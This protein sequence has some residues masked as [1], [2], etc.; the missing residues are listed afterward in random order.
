M[1][2]SNLLRGLF[3]VNSSKV[4]VNLYSAYNHKASLKRS[5]MTHV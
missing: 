4:N 1:V 5:D 2:I 3:A